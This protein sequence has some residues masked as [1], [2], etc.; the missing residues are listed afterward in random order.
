[1]TTT[2]AL[3]S[4]S[5]NDEE[6]GHDITPVQ[7]MIASCSGAIITSLFVNPLDVVKIRLQ[8]QHMPLKTNPVFVYHRGILEELCVCRYCSSGEASISPGLRPWYNRPIQF[9]GTLDAV[10]Q[11]IRSEGISSLW[12][13]LP[14]TLVM[15]IPATVI[16]FTVYDHLKYAMGYRENDPSTRYIP[17]FAGALSRVCAVTV[18][19]PLELIRTKMQSQQLSYQQLGLAVRSSVEQG[20]AMSLL[21]GL[22]PTLLR[23]VPF[24]AV[25][26]LGYE[27]LKSQQMQARGATKP[28]FTESFISGALSGMCAAILTL[29][30]DV[31]KTHRQIELGEAEMKHTT[32]TSTWQMIMRIYRQSGISALYSG[33]VPR[34]VKVAPAC[35]VMISTYEY[36]KCVFSKYNRE[37]KQPPK[38]LS[39]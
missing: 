32:P 37:H 8:A 27:Y 11:I 17:S 28:R 6:C 14:P 13:G 2:P 29:P 10:R 15:S 22:A 7:Q 30:F 38:T 33:L 36:G 3:S 25:Y 39:L 34:V 35:A 24:S 21:R 1:M 4:V 12:S 9:T 23:D 16:Y 19:N 31:V 20:G 18:I 5:S 26:W